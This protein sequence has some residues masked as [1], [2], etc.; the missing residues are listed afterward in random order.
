MTKISVNSWIRIVGINVLGFNG[1]TIKEGERFG[2][3]VS[4]P[5]TKEWFFEPEPGYL[6]G[7]KPLLQIRDALVCLN[8]AVPG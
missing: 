3:L 2:V 4:C 5:V 1:L 6:F 7:V 8:D